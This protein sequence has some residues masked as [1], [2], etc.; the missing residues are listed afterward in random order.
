MKKILTIAALAMAFQF[1]AGAN[2][3]LISTDFENEGDNLVTLDTDTG[4]EWLDLSLTRNQT[5]RNVDSILAGPVNQG[6]W[7]LPTEEEVNNLIRSIV[8]PDTTAENY[9]GSIST[10]DLSR[11]AGVMNMLGISGTSGNTVFSMGLFNSASGVA[12]AGFYTIGSNPEGSGNYVA[13]KEWLA[14]ALTDTTRDT[15]LGVFLV[16]DGGASF[17]SLNDA[18]ISQYQA[19]TISDVPAP[20]MLSGLGFLLLGLRRKFA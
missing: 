4:L 17:G 12:A 11:I 13:Y 19:P 9:A 15:S 20:A 1:S 16:S 5:M 18:N 8:F 14:G 6:V 10:D 7:R 2:A 3:E